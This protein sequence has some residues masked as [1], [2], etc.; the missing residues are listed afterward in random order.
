MNNIQE[1]IQKKAKRYGKLAPVFLEG[2]KFALEN[3]WISV[4][5][6][7]PCNHKELIDIGIRTCKKTIFVIVKGETFVDVDY[8]KL[9][10]DN[11]HWV[12]WCSI[13]HWFPI[14]ELT[15]E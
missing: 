13:T 15:K 9:S 14:P 6:D 7:L 1:K 10:E 4:E 12:R 8:M 11:W 3:Q 2:A 5:N